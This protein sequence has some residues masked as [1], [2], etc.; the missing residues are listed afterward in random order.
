MIELSA[1]VT[2]KEKG[3]EVIIT[4]S[5]STIAELFG[6]AYYGW[7]PVC[8]STKINIGEIVCCNCL[9]DALNYHR[10]HCGCVD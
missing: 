7:C 6:D 4:L 10:G 1:S 3:D 9:K 8:L 2:N 5:D